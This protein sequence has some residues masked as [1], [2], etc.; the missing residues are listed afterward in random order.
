MTVTEIK[1][2]R[3]QAWQNYI[4]MMKADETRI[5]E[6]ESQSMTFGEVTMKYGMKCFGEPGENGYPLYIALHGGGYGETPDLNNQQWEHMGIYY[7]DSVKN[8]I[9]I[10]PRGVR[11]TWDTHA[12]PESYPLYD[13][14]IENM[15]A[16][17]N[18]DPDR[19]YLMGYSAGGDGVYLVGPRMADRFAAVHM[20]AGHHNGTSILNLYNTPIQLQVGMHDDAYQRNVVTVEYMQL[21]D[22]LSREYGGGYIHNGF[23]HKDKGHNFKDWSKEE[24][25]VLANPYKW[26][27]DKDTSETM[28]DTNAV[29]FLEK[30]K[31]NPLPSRIVWD[32]GNRAEERKTTSFFWLKAAPDVTEG[33]V[34]ARLEPSVNGIVIEK[35]TTGKELCVLLNEDMVNPEETITIVNSDG[36]QRKMDM[37][38]S[39]EVLEQTTAERGDWNY[40]FLMKVE[41]N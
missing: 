2:L 10:N 4:E 14:L 1:N 40:Q 30:Y 12:N 19:V 11:D 35:N 6:V 32:L 31:R 16:F 27:T 34:V 21:L 23:V 41:V 29:H 39:K 18:A 8:G 24:Q 5:K 36:S 26:L 22:R 33:I 17:C 15:V 20:S 9:Y 7:A 28:A 37:K 38:V 25:P 3:N 13:R